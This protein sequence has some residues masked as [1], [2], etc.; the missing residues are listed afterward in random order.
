MKVL[1]KC[2]GLWDLVKDK[3]EALGENAP[4]EEKKKYT[5]I[6]KPSYKA[7]FIIHQCVSP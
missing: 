2:Q 7:L 6:E 1:S 5:E 3:F 4:E